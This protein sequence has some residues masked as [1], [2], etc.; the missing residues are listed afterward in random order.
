MQPHTP[1]DWG[2]LCA[3]V[4]FWG[5]AFMFVKIGLDTV[6]PATQVAGRT[7]TAALLLLAVIR[8]RGYRLPPIGSGWIPYAI[9]AVVGNCVPFWLISWGQQTIDSALAGILMAIMPLATLMMAHR[10]VTGEHLTRTRVAGFSLG[11]MGIVVLIGPSALVGLGGG[12][13]QI[14]A[15]LAV[16]SA[17]L[18]YATGSVLTRLI[19]RG[20][21][22][23]AAAAILTIAALIS[24]PVALLVD[25]PWQLSPSAASVMAVI[26][27]GIGPTAI[28]TLVYLSLIKSAGPTFMS[29]VHYL[30]PAVAVFS[31]VMI[32]GE[33][34]G[35]NA[36]AGLGMILSGIAA[37][38]LRRR[39][40]QSSS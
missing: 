11:F 33:D 17:A 37:S 3:L 27:I 1:K 34:P 30:A 24:V 9:L 29:L 14:V 22:L 36:Y 38:Q 25:A 5:T 39:P 15:Q 18:C 13:R 16:L 35:A 12:W 19:I 40:S 32:L 8:V 4:A 31:G 21:F 6:P 7:L 28:A 10:W 2:L 23:V 20:D 26:W